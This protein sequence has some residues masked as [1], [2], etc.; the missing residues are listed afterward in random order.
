MYADDYFS[1]EIARTSK[2]EEEKEKTARKNFHQQNTK[3]HETFNSPVGN[4][5]VDVQR[6]DISHLKI[7]KDFQL[8]N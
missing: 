7:L 5:F 3:Q 1:L 2:C 4:L 8:R 6:L